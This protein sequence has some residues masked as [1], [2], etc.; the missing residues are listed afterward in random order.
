[1]AQQEAVRQLSDYESASSAPARL[2]QCRASA[3]DSGSLGDSTDGSSSIDIVGLTCPKTT[4]AWADHGNGTVRWD[5][6][7]LKIS[8]CGQSGSRRCLAPGSS[9]LQADIDAPKQPLDQQGP[10][11]PDSAAQ[12]ISN[13]EDPEPANHAQHAVNSIPL[14][15]VQAAAE[16]P[17]QPQHG[18]GSLAYLGDFGDLSHNQR[19]RQGQQG[20]NKHVL[21]LENEGMS[22][23]GA[24]EE[25]AEQDNAGEQQW[26]SKVC[27]ACNDG[28][29]GVHTCSAGIAAYR[30]L[31]LPALRAVRVVLAS[32]AHQSCDHIWWQ[33]PLVDA[34]ACDS[35]RLVDWQFA[36]CI[37]HIHF[38]VAGRICLC[39][40][41]CQRAFHLGISQRSSR[42][43]GRDSR[44]GA[45]AE[46]GLQHA[47]HP[48]SRCFHHDELCLQAR[49][50][51]SARASSRWCRLPPAL[52]TGRIE[53]LML[54][55]IVAGICKAL[56]SCRHR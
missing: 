8:M 39:D 33:E 14:S 36:H 27:C 46:A 7:S 21:Q 20:G 12:T 5:G 29:E 23:K 16:E 32:W 22:D 34:T 13:A 38:T 24:A 42:L 6:R 26:S 15:A 47:F 52:S 37:C 40:G 4:A 31:R 9:R 25:D 48:C 53:G 56:G 17:Q 2:A 30:V 3:S 18:T 35:S 49:L 45:A 10:E 1:M 54:S 50:L 11:H 41:P 43:I 44:K 19:Q 55:A 28:G 51:P